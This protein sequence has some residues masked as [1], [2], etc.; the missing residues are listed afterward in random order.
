MAR[1]GLDPCCSTPSTAPGSGPISHGVRR[2]MQQRSTAQQ[3][4][5]QKNVIGGLSIVLNCRARPKLCYFILGL[6]IY[7]NRE[8]TFFNP[9]TLPFHASM[10]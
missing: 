7:Q 9:Q 1:T 5:I 3:G 8:I 6:V 4:R 10:V 2:T